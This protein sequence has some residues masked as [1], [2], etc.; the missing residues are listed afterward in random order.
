MLGYHNHFISLA[1][2]DEDIDFVETTAKQAFK[3]L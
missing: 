2:N 3:S 1:H